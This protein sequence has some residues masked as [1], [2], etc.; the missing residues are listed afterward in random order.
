MKRVF[1]SGALNSFTEEKG[2]LDNVH[3]MLKMAGKVRNAGFA[4]YV[5]CNDILTSISNGGL[6]HEEYYAHDLVWLGVCDA[7]ILTPGWEGS[8]GVMGEISYAKK[9]GIPVCR[10][11][12]ELELI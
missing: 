6:K 4:V 2:F 10:T 8:K 1:I 9:H 3:R 12:E 11:L 7:M 5:P